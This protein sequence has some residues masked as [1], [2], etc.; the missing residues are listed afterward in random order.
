M[1]RRRK[2]IR[3]SA[4]SGILI[5]LGLV[6]YGATQGGQLSL[7]NQVTNPPGFYS[8]VKVSDG[9]TFEVHINGNTER[10]RMI[11]VDT[12]ETKDPRRPIQCFG[13]VASVYTK[14]RLGGQ[15]VRLE[16]DPTNSN[17]DKY[18]R[19]LRYVYL[20]DGSL[21]NAEIIREGYAFAYSVYPFTK[22]EEF[23]ELERT[24]RE[25]NKGLWA[26]CNIDEAS[27]ERKQTTESK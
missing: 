26:G 14:K 9:D 7:P 17:R 1:R 18:D 21:Y 13:E 11:G 5:S 4:I 19:L 8:V 10:I 6:G 16:A 27:P 25:G 22:L 3:Y 20:S 2:T 23:R 24:A 15:S 12:P